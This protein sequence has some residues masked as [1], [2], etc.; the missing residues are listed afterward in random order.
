MAPQLPATAWTAILADLPLFSGLSKRQVRKI[1]NLATMRRYRPLQPVVR[2][3]DRGDAFFVIVEGTLL[4]RLPGRRPI[5]LRKGD[6]FG[7]MSL[8]DG[9]PR[10]AT[11]EVDQGDEVL[12]MRLGRASFLK[13]LEREPKIALALLAVVA[14][15]LRAAERSPLG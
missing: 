7:E 9:A 11:V 15:R 6:F 5:P 1:A 12:V 13:T 3:G 10:T 14:G 8:L 2:K 4:A